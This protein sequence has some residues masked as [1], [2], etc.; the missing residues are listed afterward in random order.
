MKTLLEIRGMSHDFG[1]LRAVDDFNLNLE[2]GE[3]L[4]L[5]GPNGA[6]KTTVFNLV[7]GFYR[8]THGEIL[9]SGHDIT[10]LRPHAVTAF[11]MARTFQ[12]IRLWNSLTVFENLCV[13]Q[14]CRLGYGLL[15]ALLHTRKYREQERRVKSAAEELLR[16]LD[17]SR[18]AGELPKNLPYGLQRR[19]EIGRA[20]SLH[21]QLLLLDE[22]AAGMNPGEIDDLIDLIHAVKEDYD[23]TI[24]LIEHHM[25]VVMS[26]CRRIVVIDF[27]KIIADGSPEAVRGDPNVVRAYLGAEDD[28][29]E[30]REEAGNA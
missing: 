17:I 19:V 9:F 6:G 1:G 8:P 28:P 16:R 2:Q 4:G 14:H 11:G 25:P 22:P 29:E 7:S 30:E 15:D 12:N 26:V 27:G 24:W 21:P 20:L 18:Y 5:I 3:I 13:S 23:L 10:G